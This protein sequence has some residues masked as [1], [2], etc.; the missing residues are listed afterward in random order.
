VDDEARGY[1]GG[2]AFVF[3]FV[4]GVVRHLRGC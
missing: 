3:H 4:W 2:W 1:G